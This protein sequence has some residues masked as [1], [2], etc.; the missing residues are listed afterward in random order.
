M[1]D[2]LLALLTSQARVQVLRVF[3]LDPSR[4]YYQRQLE[5]AT[6]LPIRAIQRELDRLTGIDLLYRRSEGNRAYYH[7]DTG[8]A[9]YP[10]LRSMVLKAVSPEDR[11]RGELAV[12][13]SVRL[14]FLADDGKRVL[15]VTGEG[16]AF[17]APEL[18]FSFDVMSSAQFSEAVASRSVALTPFLE[19]GLDVLGRRDDVIW[20]RIDAAGYVVNKLQGVP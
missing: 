10:E 8:F 20:R 19:R 17:T 1:E 3:M 7:V 6:G 18:P 16:K 2:A 4:P 15:L 14:A 13:D 5:A 11:L 12:D 9:L